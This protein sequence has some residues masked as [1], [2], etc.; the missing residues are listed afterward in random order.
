VEVLWPK[1]AATYARQPGSLSVDDIGHVTRTL[2]TGF[3]S[4]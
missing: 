1:K 2:A 4:A 3:P